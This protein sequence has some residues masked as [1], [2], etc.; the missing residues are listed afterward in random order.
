M[1]FVKK[2]DGTFGELPKRNV[3]FGG[4]LERIAAAKNDDPDVFRVAPLSTVISALEQAGGKTYGAS[5]EDIRAF[6]IVADHI[7]GATFMLADGVRPSNTE[8]GYIL[9]RLIRRAVRYAD[10]LSIPAGKLSDIATIVIDDY[11]NAYPE[12]SETQSTIIGEISGE[13][14]RFRET[15]SRG[16]KETQKLISLGNINGKDA[17]VLFTTYG[18]PVELTEELAKEHGVTVDTEG[19]REEMKRHQELSR[20]GSEQKFKGGLADTEE[21]T[22]RLHTA[23][24][25]LLRALQIVLGDEVHQRGS[26]ITQERLRID[27]SFGRKLTDEEKGEIE[28]IVNEKIAEQLPVIRSEMSREKAEELGAEHEFGQKYPE[29]VS[30]YSVGPKDATPEDPKFDKRYSIEFCGGPHVRNTSELGRF[31]I[32]KEEAVAQGIRRIKAVLEPHIS[33]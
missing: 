19:F 31:R 27:F 1:Q 15:L 20:A 5:K 33:S 30:V 4:G 6:R 8:R 7:R 3:D 17:A 24:H 14:A 10:G 21:K 32:Q 29:M 22:V 9:R 11:R 26:N 2:E 13:E 12:L 28:R 23:H 16:M 25:L 18:F